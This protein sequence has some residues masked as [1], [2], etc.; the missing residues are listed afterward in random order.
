MNKRQRL[1]LAAGIVIG[2]TTL[3]LHAQ[4]PS[5]VPLQTFR[6]TIDVVTIQASV[7]DTRG[8]IVSGLTPSDF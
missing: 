2:I 3:T 5:S 8:R 4:D 1:V 6:S 7:R